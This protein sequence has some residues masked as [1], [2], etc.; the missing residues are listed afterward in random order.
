MIHGIIYGPPQ[1]APEYDFASYQRR[2]FDAVKRIYA[3]G[4][5]S[6][7]IKRADAD[8]VAFIVL[9]LMD[10]CLN[11]DKVMPELADSQRPE[12]LL[13]IAFQGLVP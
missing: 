7:E 10:F 3:E 1:G 12:R 9:S 4:L 6:G 5:S 2:M 11:M 8:E 13:R